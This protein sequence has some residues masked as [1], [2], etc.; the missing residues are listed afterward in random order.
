MKKLLLTLFLP[1][2][3]LASCS[4][5]DDDNSRECDMYI[6]SKRIYLN[7]AIGEPELFYL[8]KYD[9]KEQW[10]YVRNIKDFLYETGFEYKIRVRITEYKPE[11]GV[12]VDGDPTLYECLKILTK[13]KKTSAD[14]PEGA[15]DE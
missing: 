4:D 6:A 5:D 11:Q 7:E 3:M 13:E 8:V 1:L 2:L 15:V 14:L 10:N 9:Q 12:Q